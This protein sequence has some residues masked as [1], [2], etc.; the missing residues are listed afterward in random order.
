MTSRSSDGTR[1]QTLN[2]SMSWDRM[3]FPGFDRRYV[4]GS[5]RSVSSAGVW[6]RGRER[7]LAV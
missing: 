1:S 2:A 5:R 4:N 6:E 7:M 3:S